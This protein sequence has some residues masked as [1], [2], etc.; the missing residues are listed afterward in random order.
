MSNLDKFVP[1]ST[2]FHFIGISGVGMSS[3]A[4]LLKLRGY[5][6]S[7]SDLRPSSVILPGIKFYRGHNADNVVGADVVVY[8]T[9]IGEDNVELAAALASPGKKV[10]H[11]SDILGMLLFGRHA[12]GITGTHGKT[13]TTSMTAALLSSIM[14]EVIVGGMV[15]G[16]NYI[17]SDASDFSVVEADESDLSFLKLPLTDSVVTNIEHEH[18]EF[19]GSQERVLSVYQEFLEQLP[20]YGLA[21]LCIDCPNI[22]KILRA[23]SL[24]SAVITYGFDKLADIRAFNLRPDS[25]GTTFDI[26]DGPS[27]HQD[28][29]INVCGEHNV[30]NA[31]AA[32]A[33]VLRR[34]NLPIDEIRAGLGSYTGVKR[35][36]SVLGKT[37]DGMTIVD[38][39]AHH[40]TEIR[41]TINAARQFMGD[42]NSKIIVVFQPHKFTRL[43]QFFNEFAYELSQADRVVVMPVYAAGEEKIPGYSSEELTQHLINLGKRNSIALQSN[44]DILTSVSAEAHGLVLFLGA[45]DV[46]VYAKAYY[47]QGLG[48]NTR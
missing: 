26:E 8:S 3:L 36:F 14:P 2:K 32:V 25:G 10:V 33:V 39:Y 38:D 12:I 9:A 18:M 13:S 44:E 22:R 43:K 40:P 15:S 41:A 35:R 45:G 30:L 7:G 16:K 42:V 1:L 17:Y 19:Y 46:S 47:E 21:V 6:V 5:E 27:T 29:R 4:C 28:F 31:L 34:F 24:K 20:F 11:R 23:A 48:K 37:D